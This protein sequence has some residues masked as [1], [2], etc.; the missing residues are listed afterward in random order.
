MRQFLTVMSLLMCCCAAIAQ[1]PQ[2]HH[3]LLELMGSRFEI[4]AFHSD[5]QLAWDGINAAVNEITRIER[6]ISSWDPNSQT[7]LI[8][9]NAGIKPVK[10][11]TELFQLIQRAVQIS[12]ITDGAFDIS[13]ASMDRIWQFDGTMTTMPVAEVVAQAKSRIGYQKI[14]LNPAKQEVYLKDKGMK[15]GF[16]AI[17]KGYAAQ[18][19]KEKM[20]ALGIKSGV[21]NAA[22][23]LIAWG[24]DIDGKTFRVGIADPK[25]KGKV[26]LWL[27]VKNTS[28]VTSGDYERFVMF[29]GVRYAHIIDPRTGYPTTGI[30]SVTIVSAN[31]ELAD[32]L[33]TSVFVLGV[34]KGIYLINQLD[35]VECLIVTDD[36]K[37]VTSDRLEINNKS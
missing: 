8:N 2:K 9:Q 35:G 21:V 23:D 3:K 30:K 24:V 28:V 31:P 1:Q 33:S 14:Q 37:L 10:V 17:G 25:E 32:A 11:D 29:D 26:L 13:Y 19:A 18:K 15:I 22:G 5:A 27:K 16:G 20:S 36:D 7:S 6:L 4:S 12:A 34:E